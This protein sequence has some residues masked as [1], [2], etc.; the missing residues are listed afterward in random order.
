MHA[1]DIQE[2]ARKLREA[3]GDLALAQAAQKARSFE[4]QG[5]TKQAETWRKIEAALRNM[6]GP[7]LS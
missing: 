7:R 6:Q 4:Q 5:D 2:H 3:R 1:M